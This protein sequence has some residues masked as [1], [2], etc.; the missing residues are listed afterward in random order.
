V[1]DPHYQDDRA[2]L[3]R[4]ESLGILRSLPDA[5]VDAV[6]TDPPYSSGGLMR[7]DRTVSSAEKYR[8]WSHDPDATHKPAATFAEFVGDN[9]DQRTHAFWSEMWLHEAL[10]VT[11]PGGV[12]MCFTDW[13]Q[14]PLMSDLI[15][16][17]GWVWRGIVVWDKGVARP[18]KGRFRNHIEYVLWGS[19]GPLPDADENPVYLS[20]VFRHNPPSGDRVHVT[21]KPLGLM[22]ELIRIVPP[23]RSILDPFMGSGTTGVAALGEGRSFVGIELTDHYYRL[24][25]D[26]LR[27]ALGQATAR[28]SQDALDLGASA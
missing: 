3:Y 24:A 16:M 1:T 7:G 22:R 27:A 6:I 20:S 4:G 23:G 14:L 8:G 25:E 11:R 18:V 2:T 9:R 28:D 19:C 21:E 5:S 12:L 13:R 17:V 15:Q 26:R 10:R